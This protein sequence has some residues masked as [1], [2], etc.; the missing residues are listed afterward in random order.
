MKKPNIHI[1]QF[2]ENFK[3]DKKA[4]IEK[5]FILER[6]KKGIEELD[7]KEALR[8]ILIINRNEFSYYKNPIIFAYSYFNPVLNLN[9]LMKKEEEILKTISNRVECFLLKSYWPTE[10]IKLLIKKL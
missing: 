5:I 6:G 8:R 9:E 2:I 1:S 10:Y 3:I 7:T 4:K